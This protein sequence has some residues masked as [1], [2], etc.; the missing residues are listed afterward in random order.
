MAERLYRVLSPVHDGERRCEPGDEISLDIADDDPLLTDGVVEVAD[1]DSGLQSNGGED[2]QARAARLMAAIGA[3]ASDQRRQETDWTASGKPRTEA[4]EAV[5]GLEDV[6]AAER[7]AAWEAYLA[8]K[9]GQASG[10]P[11]GV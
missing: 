2:K 7:D 11:D 4:L 1:A 5:S 6:R 3:L 8:G 9:A 10:G